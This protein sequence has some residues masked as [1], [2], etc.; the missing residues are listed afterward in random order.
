MSSLSA[1]IL[2]YNEEK[3]LQRCLESLIEICNEI[4]IVDSYSNDRTEKIS[5][6]FKAK[7]FQNPWT[8]HS[9]QLNWAIENTNINSEWILRID[10]DE[11]L[12]NQLRNSIR[13]SLN[14]CKDN[15]NGFS[16]NRLIYFMG[17][18]LKRGG[19]YPIPHLR[20][21]RNGFG[22]CE[23]R[24][25]DERIVLKSGNLIKLKGDFIDNNLNDITWWIN[26]HNHYATR[27]AIDYLNSKY[28]FYSEASLLDSNNG[29]KR[30]SFKFIYN[31][32]PLFFRPFIFFF[33]R[34][35]IQL[36]FLEGKRGFIW[37]I[38]QCFWYR[39]LIDV[40]VF[41]VYRSAG[42]RK[43]KI[44]QYFFDKFNYDINKPG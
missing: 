15:I 4:I 31:K 22:Y 10:A 20:I 26:K 33:F 18:P 29:A 2:T 5:R 34:Y 38:L 17:K 13:D 36:G 3:H 27:E 7:F 9:S 44:I 14:N 12:T 39:M 43:E 32:L 42:M 23:Q 24:W 41:E 35:F 21:W 28:D 1:I 6:E 11:Y 25:M 16:F 37:S 40:K 19:M 8:N 30:R